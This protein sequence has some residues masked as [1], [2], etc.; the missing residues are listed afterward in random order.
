MRGS[1][2]WLEYYTHNVEVVGSNPIPRY[3]ILVMYAQRR[4]VTRTNDMLSK[5][6]TLASIVCI[7]QNEEFLI[8]LIKGVYCKVLQHPR[9]CVFPIGE[10]VATTLC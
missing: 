10:M 7:R 6:D 2:V 8:H 9:K 4:C 1:S 3:Q 5:V